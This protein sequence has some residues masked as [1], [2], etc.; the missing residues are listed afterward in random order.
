MRVL[1]CRIPLTGNAGRALISDQVMNNR[2]VASAGQA[3]LAAMRQ[4]RGVLPLYIS[5][6]RISKPHGGRDS[7]EYQNGGCWSEAKH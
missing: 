6:G 2:Q 7:E 3:A 5:I 1:F 4:K